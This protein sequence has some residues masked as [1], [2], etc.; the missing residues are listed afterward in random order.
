MSKP[1]SRASLIL[2]K[3]SCMRPEV[4]TAVKSVKKSGVDLTVRIP[5]T[6]RDIATF[7]KQAIKDGTGRVIA[8]GGDGTIGAVAN[9]LMQKNRANKTS[10]GVF[11]LGAANDFARG[12]GVPREDLLR[13]FDLLSQGTRC[14]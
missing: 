11:P 4:K 9:C 5:W 1:R 13:P 8:G 3:K 12:A 6:K 10:L 14:Q 2:H 7:V